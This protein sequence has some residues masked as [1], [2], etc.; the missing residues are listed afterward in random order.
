[1]GLR[2]YDLVF[3]WVLTFSTITFW[4]FDQNEKRGYILYLYSTKNM[5]KNVL[6]VCLK[7]KIDVA[8]CEKINGSVDFPIYFIQLMRSLGVSDNNINFGNM[9]FY[10]PRLTTDHIVNKIGKKSWRFHSAAFSKRYPKH[11]LEV[12]ISQVHRVQWSFY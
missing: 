3:K 11:S 7:I 1:M 2:Q 8:I 9:I 4:G 5:S 10:L 6:E 12:W